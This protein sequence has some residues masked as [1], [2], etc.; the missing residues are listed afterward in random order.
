[1]HAVLIHGFKGWATNAWFP[2]LCEELEKRDFTT[3]SPMMPD[4]I[5]P[6][7]D[8]W[9]ET[10][11]AEIKGPDTVL[12]GHSLG[13]LAILHALESYDA[14]PLA[15]VVLVSGFGRNFG[16]PEIDTWLDRPIVFTDLRH[17]ARYWSVLHSKD[18]DVVPY[19]EGEWLA[20]QLHTSVITTPPLGHLSHGEGVFEAPPVLEA[21]LKIPRV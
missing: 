2:W 5:W 4:P 21:V 19:E 9:V 20:G 13:C 3:S 11:L 17:H 6:R 7:R 16:I 8:R 10:V 12:I 14:P 18:D 1:M 15:G